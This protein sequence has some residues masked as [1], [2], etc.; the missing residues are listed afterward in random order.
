M[1][2]GFY[3]V[4]DKYWGNTKRWVIAF[5]SKLYFRVQNLHCKR[6][7]C[8]IIHVYTKVGQVILKVPYTVQMPVITF[9]VNRDLV[10]EWSGPCSTT[11]GGEN[12]KNR[13]RFQQ[14]NTF[15]FWWLYSEDINQYL[16]A[17]FDLLACSFFM[18]FSK[19]S[20]SAFWK[21]QNPIRKLLGSIVLDK[22]LIR[23]FHWKTSLILKIVINILF[24]VH[25][26]FFPSTSL[27]LTFIGLLVLLRC[28]YIQVDV[29]VFCFVLLSCC[30][31]I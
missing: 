7:A 18:K 16:F 27:A 22:V 23:Y 31:D 15:G 12:N 25:I 17:T 21:I 29:V 5:T 6:G 28:A 19:T 3:C 2:T 1:L 14:K 13:K 24:L 4:L 26:N 10:L 8:F 11:S 30:G 20:L 9:D